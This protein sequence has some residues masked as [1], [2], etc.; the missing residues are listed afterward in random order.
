MTPEYTEALKVF[1]ELNEELNEKY[2]DEIQRNIIENPSE[3]WSYARF[4]KKSAKYPREMLFNDRKS[5][6]PEEIVEMFADFFKGLYVEDESPVIFDEV[7]GDEIDNAWEVELTMTDIEKAID[8]LDSKSSAGPDEIAPIFMKK[9]TDGLVW[10]L[11]ILH[12]KQMELGKISSK[13][14]IS[15]VVPVYKKKGKKNDVKNYRITAISSVVLKIYESAIQP[16]L[17][18]E[19]DPRITNAQHGFRPKRSVE[20]NLLN[21]SVAVHDA[22]SKKQQ[23]DTYYGDFENAFDKLWHRRLIVKMKWF[24]IGKKTTRWLFEFVHGRQFF[25]KIGNIISRV[26]EAKSGVP[27]GSILGPT[28]FLI[29]INDIVECI[30]YALPLLFADDIKLTMVIGSTTDSRQLQA[31][32]NNVL[33]WSELNRLPFNLGKCEVITIARINDPYYVTYFM[34]DHVIERKQEVRDLGIPVDT[35]FTLIA[36]MERMIT[37]ARQSMGF[38]KSVSKGQFGTRALVVLYKSYVRSKLE[39]ASVIWDPYQQNYIDDIE[40]V[41]KQFVLYALGDT[42]RIPPYRLTP[43]EERCEKLG[44]EKLSTRRQVTNAL[45]AYD[46][47]NKRIDDSNIETRF[48][49]RIQPRSLRNDRVLV[50]AMYGSTYGHNQPLAKIIRLVNEF[51]DFMTLSRS[52]FKAEVKKK[53]IGGE[54]DE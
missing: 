46:L 40:S 18:G 15:K 19:I 26:Y 35:K 16:K 20:T 22:F 32:I 30:I 9:C 23:L 41:Q 38:I 36:H 13:L 1:N 14:K 12:Q 17:L 31:D 24:R 6:Q 33:G 11:W 8:N 3:F 52:N 49:R 54:I 48:V 42:N 34:G 21:L 37:R 29:F 7:Y 47:Y 2:I 27:A 5:D 25:V 53:K 4:K 44:L 39:F 51:K 50:E 28:L 43:Y 10:P 45:M